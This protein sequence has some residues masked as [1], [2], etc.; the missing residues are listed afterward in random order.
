MISLKNLYVDID[1]PFLKLLLH[2]MKTYRPSH[3]YICMSVK[4][5]SG[6]DQP[7]QKTRLIKKNDETV[8][9][10]N[11]NETTEESKDQLST[12]CKTLY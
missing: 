9:K 5:W 4:W 10:K 11:Y 7:K 3:W 12:Q 8:A 1:I 6:Q 2:N